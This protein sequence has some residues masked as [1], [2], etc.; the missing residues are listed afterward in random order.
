VYTYKK[1]DFRGQSYYFTKTR[2]LWSNNI[3]IKLC[4][5][6]IRKCFHVTACC[7]KCFFFLMSCFCIHLRWSASKGSQTWGP[8]PCIFFFLANKLHRIAV[9]P[10]T[11]TFG[12]VSIWHKCVSYGSIQRIN[13][14]LNFIVTSLPWNDLKDSWSNYKIW[15]FKVFLV[16]YDVLSPLVWSLILALLWNRVGREKR[17]GKKRIHTF[18]PVIIFSSE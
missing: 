11:V 9:R 7:I 2:W 3:T 12:P 4:L 16:R 1:V 14:V 5:P 17:K 6:I 13:E 10:I 18:Y 8:V 15:A